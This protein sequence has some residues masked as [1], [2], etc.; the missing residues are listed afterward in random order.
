MTKYYVVQVGY[1]V[2]GVGDTPEAAVESSREWL[3]NPIELSDLPV[4]TGSRAVTAASAQYL[5]YDEPAV[6]RKAMTDRGELTT[7]SMAL[8][9][10]DG[11]RQHGIE[12][13]RL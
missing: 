9:D 3:E 5:G 10:E 4:Y 11:L 7:G 12:P 13:P 1:A 8:M 2:F 6:Q